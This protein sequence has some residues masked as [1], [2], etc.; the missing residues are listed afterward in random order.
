MTR[1]VD[2]GIEAYKLASALRGVVAQRLMR[3]L[4][5]TCKEVSDQPPPGADPAVHPRRAP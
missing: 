4:C 2:M 1:L 5:A 3:K